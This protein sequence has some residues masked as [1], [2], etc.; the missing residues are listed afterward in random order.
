[1]EII[2][3]KLKRK[4]CKPKATVMEMMKNEAQREKRLEKMNRL[5]DMWN[6][7][8]L[9]NILRILVLPGKG[10]EYGGNIRRKHLKKQR[11]KDTL[12]IE[13]QGF[14]TFKKHFKCNDKMV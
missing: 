9:L 4:H 10:G 5:S 2:A 8:K 12:H 7:S 1:M 13:T 11:E 3:D 14:T 6:N